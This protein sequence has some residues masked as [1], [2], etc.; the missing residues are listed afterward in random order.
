MSGITRPAPAWTPGA[1]VRGGAWVTRRRPGSVAGRGGG[2]GPL[3]PGDL[4]PGAG[5]RGMDNQAA[6]DVDAD[7]ADRAV[8]ED[9]VARLE[10][11]GGRRDALPVVRL[12]VG[13]V[14]ERHARGLPGTHR[15]PAAVERRGARGGPHVGLP[16]LG[17][18]VG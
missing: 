11:R 17:A 13:V 4:A 15:Q 1:S 8:E 12:G 18:G 14:R 10:R 3:P 9:E 16:E 7:V 5:V 6:A 2:G